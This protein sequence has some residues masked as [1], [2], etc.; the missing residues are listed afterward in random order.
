M[1]LFRRV[2]VV[3]VIVLTVLSRCESHVTYMKLI[4]NAELVPH[5]CDSNYLWGCVGHEGNKRICQPNRNAFGR[6]FE[7][8]G[9]VST[10]TKGRTLLPSWF[11]FICPLFEELQKHHP[12]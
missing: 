1:Y 10:A 2:L 3:F 12:V 8:N 5:P 11:T 4:P 7:S 9:R 6:D